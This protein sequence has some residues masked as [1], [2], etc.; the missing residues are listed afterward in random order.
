MLVLLLLLF[1]F[2]YSTIPWMQ[3]DFSMAKS[4]FVENGVSLFFMK[5]LFVFFIPICILVGWSCMK[6]YRKEYITAVLI[7]EFIMIAGFRMLDPL[8][9]YVLPTCQSLCCVELSIFNL[10]V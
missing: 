9:F 7:R 8:L 6:N 5:L 3:F 10:L 1:I 4:Q 2:L